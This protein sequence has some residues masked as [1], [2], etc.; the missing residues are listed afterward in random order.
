MSGVKEPES[1]EECHYFSR[2]ALDSGTKLTV[3][4]PKDAVTVMH[5]RYICGKCKHQ[6]DVTSEYK[7]PSSFVC[8]KCGTEIRIDPLK[9]KSKGIKKKKAV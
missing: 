5:V 9:G 3:W 6:A 8:E 4:V 7:M 2:R 1:M